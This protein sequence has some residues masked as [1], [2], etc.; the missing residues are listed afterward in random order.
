MEVKRIPED[1]WCVICDRELAE[2]EISH[3]GRL[4]LFWAPSMKD[5]GICLCKF[6]CIFPQQIH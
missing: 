5:R 2:V 4:H 3:N 1:H 6:R